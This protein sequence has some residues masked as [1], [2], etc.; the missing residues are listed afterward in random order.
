MAMTRPTLS[1]ESSVPKPTPRIA[2]PNSKPIA[3]EQMTQPR[4]KQ[5][6]HRPSS[7]FERMEMLFTMPSPGF[8]IS[9]IS[10]VMAAPMPV[11]RIPSA[12][13]NCIRYGYKK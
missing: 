2:L 11:S 6:L 8:G 9:I 3:R 4:S 1:I 12:A 5:F 10:T 7:F 13:S